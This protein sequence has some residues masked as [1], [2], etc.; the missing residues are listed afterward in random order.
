MKSRIFWKLKSD[1]NA[2]WNEGVIEEKE[3]ELVKIG[4]L[5]YGTGQWYKFEDLLIEYRTQDYEKS[6][7]DDIIKESKNDK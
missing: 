4:S 2:V 3:G 6:K 1:R 5:G 7:I